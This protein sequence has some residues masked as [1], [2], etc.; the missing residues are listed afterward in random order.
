MQRKNKLA[1]KNRRASP[2]KR[3]QHK[4]ASRNT[5]ATRA[6]REY[7]LPY[8][9]PESHTS[10]ETALLKSIIAGRDSGRV[11]KHALLFYSLLA[12]TTPS[13]RALNYRHGI[14]IGRS[15]YQLYARTRRYTLYEESVS[16]IVSFFEH[17]GYGRVTYQ[18]LPHVIRIGMHD[19]LHLSLGMNT[20]MFEA[21][22]IAGFITASKGQLTHVTE[23]ECSSNSADSCE[24]YSSSSTQV[25]D[26]P[27]VKGVFDA[28]VDDVSQHVLNREEQNEPS[29]ANE[30]Y[31]LSSLVLLDSKYFNEMRM[32][33]DYLG[34]MLAARLRIESMSPKRMF[35][36]FERSIGLLSMGVAKI[37]SSD[38]FDVTLQLDKLHSRKEFADLSAAFLQGFLRNAAKGAGIEVKCLIHNNSYSVRLRKRKLRKRVH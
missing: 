38:K 17:A 11:S 12:N 20:H 29:M 33:A 37:K 21:G 25:T 31:T 27:E 1:R 23:R 30:Y 34:G 7:A 14:A 3:K 15:L 28:F 18:A 36:T 22:L 32:L 5:R 9:L 26:N 10:Y 24:F 4:H 6:K 2:A 35:N 13:M 16:D 19:T 8:S